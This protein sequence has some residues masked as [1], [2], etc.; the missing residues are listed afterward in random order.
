[1]WGA[2]CCTSSS[3]RSVI[4]RT[5]LCKQRSIKEKPFISVSE[6][7]WNLIL[8]SRTQEPSRFKLLT[9]CPPIKPPAPQ[10]N[11]IFVIACFCLKESHHF[12]AKVAGNYIRSLAHQLLEASPESTSFRSHI[13][14]DSSSVTRILIRCPCV[15]RAE[16]TRMEKVSL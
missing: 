14:A 13:N 11:A 1:M 15:P 3:R 10:T 12:S 16:S 8:M 4:S 7:S 5:N 2:S 9:K 6:C